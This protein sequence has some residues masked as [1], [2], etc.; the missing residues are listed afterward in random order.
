MRAISAIIILATILSACN[1]QDDEIQVKYTG[2]VF[3]TFYSIIY[4]DKDTSVYQHQID[5]ILKK[6][7]HS[8]SIYNPGSVVSKINQGDTGTYVVDYF[9]KDVMSKALEISTKTNNAFDVTVGPLVNAWGFGFENK[10]K[11]DSALIDSLLKIVGV[12]NVV[13]K[14]NQLIKRNKHTVLDFNAIAKGY[15]V[16]IIGVFLKE[17]GIDNYLVEIGGEVVAK[18]KKPG[19][20]AWKIGIEEPAQSSTDARKLNSVIELHNMA[21]ATSGN[22]RNYYI[23][24]GQRYSHTLDPRTGYPAK[25][26]LL[27]ATVFASSCLEADAYATAFMVIG[28]K[29]SKSFLKNNSKLDAFFIY[30]GTGNT[31]KTY[32]TQKIKN[33][34]QKV[35]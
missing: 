3:G 8:L 13:L 4:Y 15:G 29:K 21:V 1:T 17:Q 10:A 28:L 2:K 24:N 32:S 35:K 25:N 30:T 6:L 12:Q 11:I 31:Y 22:Y 19:N 9:F 27:S 23:E 20:R 18:G 34:I 16:D 5:S 14:N 26:R 7:D 33:S